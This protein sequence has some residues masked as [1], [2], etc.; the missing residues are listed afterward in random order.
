[1]LNRPAKRGLGFTLIEMVV[2]MA[3][4][5]LLVALTIP[6]MR[7]WVANVKVRAV[8]DALQNGLRLAQAESLR[9]SRQMV[10][11]LTNS[12]TPQNGFT[13]AVNGIYWSINTVPSM[14]DGTETAANSFVES[15]VL[16][17]TTANVAV[18][19]AQAAIC[20]NSVGRLVANGLPGVTGITGGPTCALPT[21]T[22]P[23][24]KYNITTTG[25]DRPLQV[26]MC[27]PNVVFSSSN[28]TGC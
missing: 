16:T 21:G 12:S 5:A 15:G 22:P 20:F 9:R 13:A 3:V 28:P 18:T 23:V 27:D 14:T 17:S 1:M 6:T 2:T 10:F 25:G 4:F 26:H 19:A 11:S 7:T 24:L 8:A